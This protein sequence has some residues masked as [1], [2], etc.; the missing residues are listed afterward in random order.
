MFKFYEE[1]I[2]YAR[3]YFKKGKWLY[4]LQEEFKD[5]FE[6]YGCT[7]DGEPIG[8]FGKLP[9]FEDVDFPHHLLSTHQ[10]FK[11]ALKFLQENCPKKVSS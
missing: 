5:R 9:Y 10:F 2:G 3:I 8:S 6:F 4:C 7:P 1:D 11:D